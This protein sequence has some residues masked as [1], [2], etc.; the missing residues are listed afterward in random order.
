[1]LNVFLCEGNMLQ[2][3]RRT[4]ALMLTSSLLALSPGQAAIAQEPD[5]PC[6]FRNRTGQVADLSYLCGPA[7]AGGRIR[8]STTKT[9]ECTQLGQVLQQF[10]REVAS[11]ELGR[12]PQNS[13]G[14][15]ERFTGIIDQYSNQI[16][17]LQM[18][19]AVLITLRS[20]TVRYLKQVNLVSK[21][22][23][24]AAKAKNSSTLQQNLAAL[25]SMITQGDELDSELN[26]YC[27]FEEVKR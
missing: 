12:T 27:G 13:L 7:P 22:M 20:R 21:R 8:R 23:I 17:A 16:G 24:V 3:T 26:R 10:A 6:Y 9:A 14:R 15:L 11:L 1:M 4:I 5:S 19:D 25:Q 18:K 2:W